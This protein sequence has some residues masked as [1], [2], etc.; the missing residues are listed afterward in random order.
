MNRFESAFGIELSGIGRN[1]SSLRG[2]LRRAL[3][4]SVAVL[5][6]IALT[7]AAT[8]DGQANS[9]AVDGT[10]VQSGGGAP[11]DHSKKDRV[12]LYGDGLPP[13]ALLRLGT[14]RMRQEGHSHMSISYSPDGTK[15]ATT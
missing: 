8:A 10:A 2:Q 1:H 11:Q 15:L 12:D 3:I 7:S 5:S 4:F 13:G 14:V 6:V 9:K